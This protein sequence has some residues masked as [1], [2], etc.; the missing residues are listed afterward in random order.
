M[1]IL[2]DDPQ[3]TTTE[4]GARTYAAGPTG[5]TAPKPKADI[6]IGIK[7]FNDRI[8]PDACEIL[9]GRSEQAFVARDLFLQAIAQRSAGHKKI[10]VGFTAASG[11]LEGDD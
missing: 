10:E 9:L 3:G 6:P 1:V 2:S 11:I 8:P 4:R 5:A 7:S